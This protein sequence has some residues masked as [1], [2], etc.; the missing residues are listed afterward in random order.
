[1]QS[2]VGSALP[3]AMVTVHPSEYQTISLCLEVF[4]PCSPAINK[5]LFCCGSSIESK[6]KY[7][8]KKLFNKPS[9]NALLLT[10]SH[11][12][13]SYP[14]FLKPRASRNTA[15]LKSGASLASITGSTEARLFQKYSTDFSSLISRKKFAKTFGSTSRDMVI[16]E[17][18]LWL[19]YLCISNSR[20]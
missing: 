5:L 3:D 20:L 13:G 10:H 6:S 11:E 9:K 19:K 15:K 18:S 7:C 14:P 16:Q 2:K 1:M 8:F 4:W 12:C 17:I